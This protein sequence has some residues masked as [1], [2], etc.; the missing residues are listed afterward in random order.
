M[1]TFVIAEAGVNH[2]GKMS[3]AKK[4]IKMAA[5]AGADCVKFQTFT[6]SANHIKNAQKANYQKKNTSSKETL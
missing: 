4:L 3:V 5:L 1:K 2:N 6:A